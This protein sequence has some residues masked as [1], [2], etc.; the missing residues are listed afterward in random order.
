MAAFDLNAAQ[1]VAAGGGSLPAAVGTGFGLPSCLLT[2]GMDVLKLIPS[3]SLFGMKNDL[4]NG[5][6]LADDVVKSIGAKLRNV[7]GIIE[8]DSEEGGFTF[9]SNASKNGYDSGFFGGLNETAAFLN[10]A[11]QLGAGLWANY[12]AGVDQ[13]N[14][15]RDCFQ[16]YFDYLKYKNGNAVTQLPADPSAY[17]DYINSQFAVE[18]AALNNA[19][20]FIA[21]ATAL[22]EAINDTLADRISDPGL[23]PNFSC[24]AADI[25]Y[26]TN[27]A[28]NCE[29]PVIEDKP[30]FRLVYGPPRS[31]FGQFI[32][33]NDGIY[34]DSQTSGI[35]PALVYL[36]DKRTSQSKSDQ[37]KLNQDPNLGGRGDSFSTEDLKLYLNTILDFNIIDDSDFLKPYYDKDGFLQELMGNRNKRI[38][39]LSSQI[40]QLETDNAPQSIIYN[41]KQSLISENSTLQE[42]INKRKKQI[43]LAVKLPRDFRVTYGITTEY[44]P[45]QVPIND[46]TYLAG[47]NLSLDLEKQKALTFS[48]EDIASV[49]SPISTNL[50]TVSRV[51]TKNSSLEHLIIPE[52]GDGAIIYDGSSV[53]A[54]NAVILPTES[55]ITTGGMV[56]MYN[57]LDTNIEQPSS[58]N[59]S[60]RNS[61]STTNEKYAQLVTT[62]QDYVFRAGLGI[63]YLQGITKNFSTCATQPQSV[64]SFVKLPN[65]SQFNDLLY[66][67]NGATVDFWA[68]MPDLVSTTSVYN[69]DGVSSLYRLVLAN[70]NTGFT[71][72]S[73]ASSESQQNDFGDRSVRGLILGFTRDR[74][75]CSDAPP[76]NNSLDN[77]V[78]K[79]VFFLAPTQSTSPSSVGLINRNSYDQNSCIGGNRYHAMVTYLS[80]TAYGQ[81]VSSCQ[82]EFCHFAVAM[83]PKQDKLEIYLDGN[84]INTSSLS[85][86]FG[87]EKYQMPNIP[88]FKKGNSFEYNLSSV[89]TSAPVAL[90]YG[91]K[92]D[93]YFTPWIVGGGYTDGMSLY[94][95]F[96]G[97]QYGGIISGLR[98]YLGSLKFYSKPLEPSEILNNYKAHSGFFKNIDI[99]NLS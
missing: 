60:L 57:F 2:L 43:E 14:Q 40:N 66:N 86:V 82:S 30:I 13:V 29:P 11:A 54:T 51:F 84:L 39:D 52:N 48:Q 72:S 5:V 16:T 24:E 75:L 3:N 62:D 68:H 12:Q 67:A 69:A 21:S 80:S 87:I 41:Y 4:N 17:A 37:W 35:V 31:R 53:S 83:N 19:V 88:T 95:N 56:A 7:F 27:L 49:V 18:S 74:R 79:S 55:F 10:G 71:G 98:G 45:G 28:T 1:T 47:I 78:G 70:E 96:L 59:F 9:V 92:L 42:P 26:G 15:I 6:S 44:S 91:P 22:I 36:N 20:Q 23:E 34:F 32:L 33:S 99:S 73:I 38:Y 25:F 81:A 93:T 63:P 90:K 94:G 77:P 58:T 8:W 50:P 64:G 97:G 85:Y 76:S 46:F 89:G 65:S 61:H